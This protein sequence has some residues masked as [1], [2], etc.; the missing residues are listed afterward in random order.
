MRARVEFVAPQTFNPAVPWPSAIPP[1]R[2]ASPGCAPPIVRRPRKSPPTPKSSLLPKVSLN[3]PRM[4]TCGRKR[5]C[6]CGSG[7]TKP[8]PVPPGRRAHG[9]S[10]GFYR[11]DD[12]T[13]HRA[14][15]ACARRTCE[16]AP[17]VTPGPLRPARGSGRERRR[18][19]RTR[20]VRCL[21]D[22][23]RG[24]FHPPGRCLPLPEFR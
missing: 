2:L 7:A 19:I 14:W 23:S 16:S 22:R 5:S 3:S 10:G 1:S 13:A 9:Q 6:S 24:R 20:N 21:I 18:P 12:T 8:E 17:P 15:R 4:S 11:F